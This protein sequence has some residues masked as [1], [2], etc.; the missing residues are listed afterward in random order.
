MYSYE[1]RCIGFLNKHFGMFYILKLNKLTNK[2][3]T[4]SIT[5]YHILIFSGW[6]IGPW[7]PIPR[8]IPI[9]GPIWRPKP[10]P[11]RPVWPVIPMPIIRSEYHH[12]LFRAERRLC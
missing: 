11:W 5:K 1:K 7:R 8:P 9:P 3:D 6:P 4:Q 2:V 10:F 12:T